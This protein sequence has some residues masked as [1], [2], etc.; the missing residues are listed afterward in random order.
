M[1]TF[2]DLGNA[3]FVSIESFRKNGSSVKTPVW[4]TQEDGK[5]YCWT[6]PTTWK[7]KRIRNHPQ[8]NLAMCDRTGNIES[9]WVSACGRILDDPQEVKK[10]AGRMANKYGLFFRMFQLMGMLRHT[11]NVA[12]EFTPMTP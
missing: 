8:V 3:E 5:L 10:Q 2:Q 7:V 9:D 1:T 11:N 4:I 12:I 6:V